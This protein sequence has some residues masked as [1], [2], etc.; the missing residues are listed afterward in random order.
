MN[1]PIKIIWKYKNNNRRVQYNTY[2]FIGDV[3]K[4]I[5]KILNIIKGLS[6]YDTL[7]TLSIDEYKILEKIYGDFWYKYFF[8]IYHINF[9][10]SSIKDNVTQKKELVDKYGDIWF[11]KHINKYVI[12]ERKIFYT[13]DALIKERLT[14]KIIKKGKQRAR[15]YAP[16]LDEITDFTLKKKHKQIGGEDVDMDKFEL[17]EEL[18]SEEIEDIFKEDDVV[19][20]EHANE[21]ANLIKEAVDN[22]NII[23]EN[24]KLVP[25]ND[26]N[27]NETYDTDLKN[28]FKK[29]YVISQY[30][31]LDDTIKTIRTKI[32]CGL[33]MSNKFG[34][35]F[36]LMPSRQ[37]LW[38]EY[39]Y[40]N[41]I[42][43]IMIGQ[44]WT[45][46][47]EL[48][49]VD[50]EP[51][52]NIRVY[53]ELREN[54]K[55]LRDDMR[56]YGSKIKME[57][58]NNY[59]LYD[60][61]D[62]LMNNEI[63][64]IDLYNE[65][66]I[67]YTT[68]EQQN[69]MD[70]YIKIYFP[71][72]KIDDFINIVAFLNDTTK[73]NELDK[74]ILTYNTLNNDLIMENEIMDAVEKE[75]ITG[76]SE[77]FDVTY[78]T[79]SAVNVF[80]KQENKK[81]INLFKIFDN[82]ILDDTYSIIRYQSP[83]RNIIFKFNEKDIQKQLT[84]KISNN[85]LMK[86]FESSGTGLSF[87]VKTKEIHNASDKYIIISIIDNG[88]I[89]Y[90]TQWKEEEKATI[91]DIKL[92]FKYVIDLIKKINSENKQKINIP[93]YEEFKFAFINSIQRFY[94]PKKAIIN[95]NDLSDF[96]RLFYPYISLVIDP[97]KRATKNLLNETKSKY[98]TYLRYRRVSNYDNP[99]KLEQRI[100]YFIK[101]YEFTTA[102]LIK[103]LS[104]QF[105]IT[106]E[107][108][109]AEYVKVQEKYPY[110]KKS[111]KVLKKLEN[112]PKY[113]PPGISVEIQGKMIDKYTIRLSGVKDNIYLD[114]ITS[115]INTLLHLYIKVYIKKEKEYQHLKEILKNLSKIA[116]RRHKVE[117]VV[118]YEKKYKEIKE[119]EKKD[120]LRIG[121]KPE[122]GQNQWTRACQNSGTSRRRPQQRTIEELIKEGYKLNK[123][124][125]I[126][127]KRIILKN[128]HRKR[129]ET[130]I[131]A[132]KL[133]EYN[134][135]GIPTENE[136]YYKCD[137]KENGEYMYIGFLTK[138][139]NPYGYCM[140]CCFKKDPS[141]TTNTMKK[142]FFEKCLLQEQDVNKHLTASKIDK[143]YILQDSNKIQEGRIG[144]LQ[145]YLDVYLNGIT[146]K[147][148]V[149]N[150]NHFL[151]QSENGYLLKRGIFQSETSF[152][153]AM[154]FILDKTIDE[155]KNKFISILESDKK[156]RIFTFLNEGDIKTRFVTR[157]NFIDFIKN[158]IHI[159]YDMVKDLFLIPNVFTKNGI[160]PVIFVKRNYQIKEHNTVKN[161]EDFYIKCNNNEGYNMLL[162]YDI[163]LI[164]QESNNYYPIINVIKKS[165]TDSVF[166]IEKIF[167]N[168]DIVNHINDFYERTCSIDF[169]SET[170]ST[171]ISLIAR[172]INNLL[173]DIHEF[174]PKYQVIDVRNKC[175]YLI[176]NKLI[177]PT[178]PS[179]CIYN[180]EIIKGVSK[181]M[182]NFNDTL[183]EMIKLDKLCPKLKIKPIGVY[184]DR[185]TDNKYHVIAITTI[186]H[187][188]IPI[189]PEDIE[190]EVIKDYTKENKPLYN[191]IDKEILTFRNEVIPD[192][193]I[194]SV[195]KERYIDESYQLFRFALSNYI[196]NLENAKFKNKIIK[197]INSKNKDE[198][199]KKIKI[200]L[201]KLIDDKLV[202][203]YE[204]TIQGGGGKLV[205]IIQFPNIDN[206][207]I[208]NTR[209]LCEDKGK[210]ECDIHCSYRNNECKLGIPIELAVHFVSKVTNELISNDVKA[211]EILNTTNEYYVSDVVDYNKYT[212]RKNQSVIS[213]TSGLL[214]KSLQTLFGTNIPII[215]KTYKLK[216]N[217]ID[218]IQLNNDNP[219]NDIKDKYI[220]R[221]IPDNNTIIRAFA[222]GFYWLKH[223]Y[224]DIS[225][226][227]IGYY[228][229]LQNELAIYFKSVIIDWLNKNKLEPD[230]VKYIQLSKKEMKK[231]QKSFII[232][233]WKSIRTFTNGVIEYYVLNKIFGIVIRVYDEND[234]VM[235]IF[236]NGIKKE[237]NINKTNMINIRFLGIGEIPANVDVIYYK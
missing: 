228:S 193:R 61:N 229:I 96:S 224:D 60:Y 119:M 142:D 24:S 136:I 149:L 125:G 52:N 165:K 140:P 204:E 231:P 44:K 51:D 88:K 148:I 54:L 153:N 209:M 109:L 177:I 89:E 47:A 43:K 67:G 38:G 195:N 21:T 143:L 18:D 156:D 86:W 179:C 197:L 42:N 169:I 15:E 191:I 212:E 90:K 121:F 145:K 12:F 26:I 77:F 63:F 122:K 206:Y 72:I 57:E 194:R 6:L 210:E 110:V 56:R 144:F 217:E 139:S 19:L 97:K 53:E 152:I 226:R 213:S 111:R 219:L 189:L 32:C 168:N 100:L 48:L 82:F 41:K 178:K 30:I 184:Y 203:L 135:E 159:D 87:K 9:T 198:S 25:F 202:R 68:T 92:T 183:N 137:P 221:I 31:Y 46:K 8:N 126:Y 174:K 4:H 66:G 170:I 128:K 196:N 70:L 167:N 138:S 163:S 237:T 16:T 29:D 227:N 107:K 185:M 112:I 94:L 176:T 150:N 39:Y 175:I 59:I 146:G 3:N 101:N 127:E 186:T 5:L 201:Y 218:Y 235:Y 78:I 113:K 180:L 85:L 182:H 14:S 91:E 147:K 132:V 232:K 124:T 84:N 158:T 62:Y 172:K 188:S 155:I 80:V 11:E 223:P 108:A 114:W 157:E 215:G 181:Y 199:K 69:L 160:L 33:K 65:L 75:R 118:I 200:M 208:N 187:E 173:K 50:I 131:K 154:A 23:K 34:D 220:Q 7:T 93:E 35:D 17:Q 40:E 10:V 234:E 81:K 76:K 22:K 103:E 37:Y 36:Y 2:I 133:Q 161:K 28:E 164:V 141:T 130:I 71:K 58:D 225:I 116:K 205:N 166:E 105:N 73:G 222:N 98:G 162:D 64:M 13:Y 117:D 102:Q 120:K 99:I 230:I 20:D 115:F 236:D 192:D 233:I 74:S 216:T 1:H 214:K 123:S 171:H 45:R 207:Q 151:V 79:Q 129:T 55:L 49:Q 190:K 211:M 134:Q 104:K 106:E 83:N 27:D 95:H